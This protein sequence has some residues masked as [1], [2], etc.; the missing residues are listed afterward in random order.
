MPFISLDGEENGKHND[1]GFVEISKIFAT[2]DAFI[3]GRV[4]LDRDQE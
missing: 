4:A 1:V 3:L 2:L